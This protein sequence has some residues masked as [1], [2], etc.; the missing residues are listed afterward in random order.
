MYSEKARELRRCVA[1][2]KGSGERCTNAAVWTDSR[3]LCGAHGGRVARQ[4]IREKTTYEPCTCEAY[5]FPHRPGSGIC[6][7]PFTPLYRAKMRPGTHADGAKG[8]KE[9]RKLTKLPT[10]LFTHRL[11][12]RVYTPGI[13]GRP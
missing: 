11:S 12:E 3:G 6:N 9:I 1:V 8:R 10:A 4:H 5:P 13:Y 2:C 7:W